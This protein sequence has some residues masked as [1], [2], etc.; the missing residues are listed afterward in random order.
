MWA[1][2]HRGFHVIKQR[3]SVSLR[4]LF[5]VVTQMAA[6]IGMVIG[7]SKEN[8]EGIPIKSKYQLLREYQ[9]SQHEK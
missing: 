8:D 5:L 2:G 1:L 3:R 7:M 6:A 9:A 4:D